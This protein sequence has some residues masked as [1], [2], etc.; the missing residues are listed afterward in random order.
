MDAEHLHDRTDDQDYV[1]CCE[2]SQLMHP[3]HV[4]EGVLLQAKKTA[5]DDG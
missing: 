3:H 5:L 2:E 4:E 1:D